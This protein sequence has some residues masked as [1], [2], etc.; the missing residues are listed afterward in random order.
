MM[1]REKNIK[2]MEKKKVVVGKKE[3][4]ERRI[5]EIRKKIEKKLKVM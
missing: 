1:R 3:R 4:K 2:I 5:K